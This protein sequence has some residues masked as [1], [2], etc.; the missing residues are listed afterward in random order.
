MPR[1]P[2]ATIS[3]TA[4][5]LGD[6]GWLQS[7]R[8]AAQATHRGCIP[9]QCVPSAAPET[10]CS[11]RHSLEGEGDPQGRSV[12]LRQPLVTQ[13][14]IPPKPSVPSDPTDP[15]RLPRLPSACQARQ[16]FSRGGT[17][18]FISI[19]GWQGR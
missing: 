17:G 9:T 14:A 4:Q 8:G 5:C 15:R 6:G 19:T 18:L 12:P 10:L 3:H 13:P 16:R 2:R 1:D 11:S 7:Q